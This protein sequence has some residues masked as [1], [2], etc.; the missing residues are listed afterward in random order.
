LPGFAEEAPPAANLENS[1]SSH[2]F[3]APDNFLRLSG[4][5]ILSDDSFRRLKTKMKGYRACMIGQKL[6]RVATRPKTAKP[7]VNLPFAGFKPGIND[8]LRICL[9]RDRRVGSMSPDQ[10]LHSR[11]RAFRL[12]PNND[13]N[14]GPASGLDGHAC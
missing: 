1:R 3:R 7:G 5:A 8:A 10:N 14:R 13:S 4:S 6:Q 2:S 11:D 12:I 9:V